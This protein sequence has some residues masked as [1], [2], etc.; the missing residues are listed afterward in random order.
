MQNKNFFKHEK[1]W[2][3]VYIWLIHFIVQQKLAQHCKVTILQETIFL[4]E[5]LDYM[6]EKQRAWSSEALQKSSKKWYELK[7]DGFHI[8][9]IDCFTNN[10]QNR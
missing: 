1:E 2:V 10:M 4:K 5:S 9:A 3:H 8:L 7:T 6:D